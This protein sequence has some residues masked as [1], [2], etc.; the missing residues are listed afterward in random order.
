MKSSITGNILNE[1]EVHLKLLL[2]RKPDLE[3]ILQACIQSGRAEKFEELAFTGKYLQGL[4]RVLKKGAE[5][6]EIESLEN[7]KQDLSDNM[8]MI[9]DQ[10]RNILSNQAEEIK[11]RF[12]ETYFTLSQVNF[13]N[14]N[15]LLSD[16][17]AVKKYINYSKR[18]A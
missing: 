12:E 11:S 10:M 13:Q 6:T 1:T 14:L 5:I 2:K 3:I 18:K 8:E 15:E 16:L 9:I 17:E 7:V 4:M